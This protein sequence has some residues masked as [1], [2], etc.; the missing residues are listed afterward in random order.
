MPIYYPSCNTVLSPTCSDCP[1]KELGGI[2]SVWFQHVN[3]AWVDITNPAEWAAKICSGDVFVLPKTRGSLEMAEVTETGF[4]DIPMDISGYDFTLNV[5]DPNYLGNCNFWNSIKKSLDY[6]VGYR[7][8]SQIY[9]SSKAA[10]VIPKAPIAEDIKSKV[11]W[12]ATI[13][14]SQEDIPCPTNMPVSVFDQCLGC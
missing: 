10:L 12:N 8:E 13:K 9:V 3:V 6:K 5:F 2:R 1:P 4:G 7:T 14:F 11:I